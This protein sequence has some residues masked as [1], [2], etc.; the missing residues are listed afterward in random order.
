MKIV[1]KLVYYT[2]GK[3]SNGILFIVAGFV[4]T[5]L[6][7]A[8][9]NWICVIVGSVFVA[10]GVVLSFIRETQYT[11][12][13]DNVSKLRQN[14]RGMRKSMNEIRGQVDLLRADLIDA[15][16]KID[17]LGSIKIVELANGRKSLQGR[18]GPAFEARKEEKR[19]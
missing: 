11:E 16:S 18:R 3:I 4:A 7:I 9:R 8:F 19:A 10:L 6:G 14:Q 1:S 13:V 5:M 2:F 12:A 17:Q 15:N